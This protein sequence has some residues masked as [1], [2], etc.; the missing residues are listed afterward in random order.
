[1]ILQSDGENSVKNSWREVKKVSSCDIILRFS[2]KG[3]SQSLGEGES[4]NFQLESKFRAEKSYLEEKLGTTFKIDDAI[5]QWII[6]HVG[7]CR[8]RYNSGADGHTGYSRINGAAYHGAVCQIGE[9]VMAKIQDKVKKFKSASFEA[10]WLGKSEFDDSHV[11][12]T[13]EKIWQVRTV[14][15]LPESQRWKLENVLN[16]GG[17]PSD[18]MRAKAQPKELPKGDLV[19]PRVVPEAKPD[20]DGASSSSSS[21][22]SDAGDDAPGEVPSVPTVPTVMPPASTPQQPVPA[23]TATNDCQ[24]AAEARSR[25]ASDTEHLEEV[26]WFRLDSTRP[27]RRKFR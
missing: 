15:R 21:S 17:I 25:S 14:H 26:S 5:C 9:T 10:V 23:A 8:T 24:S 13:A 2:P 16:I 12:G 20:A 6:K 11:V 22:S 1:V 7:F 4:I 3:S 19:L 27:Q 18:S